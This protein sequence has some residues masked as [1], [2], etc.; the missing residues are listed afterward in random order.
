VRGTLT[1]GREYVAT[2]VKK[3]RRVSVW[4]KDAVTGKRV[5]SVSSFTVLDC[6]LAC[7]P[8]KRIKE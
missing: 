3:G 4:I 2:G 6:R 5:S 8:W 7:L 1:A